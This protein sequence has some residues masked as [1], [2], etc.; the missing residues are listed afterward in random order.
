MSFRKS[1]FDQIKWNCFRKKTHVKMVKIEHAD[2]SAT[3]SAAR[4]ASPPAS[5]AIANDEI[6][7]GDAIAPST[8]TSR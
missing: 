5:F 8:I 4:S 6:A 7:V 2:P 1:F 3:I